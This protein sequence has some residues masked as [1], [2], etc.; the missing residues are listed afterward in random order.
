MLKGQAYKIYSIS[1]SNNGTSIL[2]ERKE[3]RPQKLDYDRYLLGRPYEIF[4][5]TIRSKETLS[6]YRKQLFAFCY[7]MK[8]NTEDIVSKY[9]QF[10]KVKGKNKP[11]L[12]GQIELQKIVEDYVLILQNKVN[13]GLI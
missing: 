13:K 2:T 4:K 3:K 12:E 7:Y 6:L 5:G 8:M 1:S 10:I 11:N 9:G